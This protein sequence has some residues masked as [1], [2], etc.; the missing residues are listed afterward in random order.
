VSARRA[1]YLTVICAGLTDHCNQESRKKAVADEHAMKAAYKTFY[2]N[3]PYDFAKSRAKPEK[4][5]KLH[6]K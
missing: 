2:Q 5:I 4:T 3:L 6:G 1:L